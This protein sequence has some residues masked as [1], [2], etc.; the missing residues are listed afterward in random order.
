MTNQVVKAALPAAGVAKLR[1]VDKKS[2]PKFVD[3][4]N[5]LESWGGDDDWQFEF[6]PEIQKEPS[7]VEVEESVASENHYEDMSE[8]RLRNQSGHS[9]ASSTPSRASL[10]SSPSYGFSSPIP[11]PQGPLRIHPNPDI[12]FSPSS[13]PGELTASLKMTNVS[14]KAVAYKLK[15]TTPEMFRVRP[16]SGGLA[17]GQLVQVDISVIQGSSL[18]REKFLI[19]TTFVPSV[20]SSHQEVKAALK[21][22][23]S[24]AEYR[25]RCTV[26]Q[27]GTLVANGAPG[28]K[29]APPAGGGAGAG[30]GAGDGDGWVGSGN[31]DGWNGAGGDGDGDGA[32]GAR[33]VCVN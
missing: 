29:A 5:R 31:D 15:T 21:K 13:R 33:Y 19:S 12:S 27:Q 10:D 20:P 22:G 1:D 30:A 3:D 16:S 2:F 17:P 8:L 32:S 24:D 7:R 23:R 6:E 9:F 26:G 4:D 18:S 14:D 28:G 25:L 11:S